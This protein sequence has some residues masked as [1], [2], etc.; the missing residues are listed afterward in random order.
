MLLAGYRPVG[1]NKRGARSALFV[2]YGRLD[3]LFTFSWD[4]H[5]GQLAAELLTAGEAE[6]RVIATAE[7]SGVQSTS[8]IEDRLTAFMVPVRSF[9][10]SMAEAPPGSEFQGNLS[11]P[12]NQGD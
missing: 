5:Q 3:D 6:L 12:D 9:L 7:F 2:D 10:E 8:D 4:K 1:R 11:A